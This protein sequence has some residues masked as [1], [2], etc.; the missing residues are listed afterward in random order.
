MTTVVVPV[1]TTCITGVREVL[2]VKLA[3]PANTAV[4][5]W[6]PRASVDVMKVA[7]PVAFSVPVPSVVAPSKKVTVPLGLPDPGDTTLIVAVKVTDVLKDDGFCEDMT[8]VV[9]PALLTV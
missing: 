6:L 7:I 8:V 1:F 3:S 9:V 4:M 5:V 2:P